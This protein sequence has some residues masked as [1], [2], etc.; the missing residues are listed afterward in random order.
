M[1]DL[2]KI[3]SIFNAKIDSIK[4]KD[5]LQNLKTEF[6]GK[7]GQ[8]TN[9]FK[10]LGSLSVEQKK[11]FASSLNKLKASLSNQIETKNC[12]QQRKS[13]ENRQPP[14]IVD[15]SLSAI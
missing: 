2:D 1:S 6:F 4:S 12:Y 15:K 9:Q 7:N 14:G 11:E 3:N 5:E 8:I 10:N 13:R